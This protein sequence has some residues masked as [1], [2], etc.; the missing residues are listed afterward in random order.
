MTLPNPMIYSEKTR[1]T[2][3]HQASSSSPNQKL[4]RRAGDLSSSNDLYGSQQALASLQST[5]QAGKLRLSAG[6]RQA[7]AAKLRKGSIAQV[8]ISG[9][10]RL[11]H[12]LSIKKRHS[13]MIGGGAE[14]RRRKSS[15]A[16]SIGALFGAHARPSQ[17]SPSLG[18]AYDIEEESLRRGQEILDKYLEDKER[19]AEQLRAR[20]EAEQEQQQQQQHGATGSSP[21]INRKS[22]NSAGKS[23]TTAGQSG[24][25]AGGRDQRTGERQPL[26]KSVSAA[27]RK[28]F[29]ASISRLL[30]MRHSS[31]KLIQP[32]QPLLTSLLASNTSSNQMQAATANNQALKHSDSSACTSMQVGETVKDKRR[33]LF[34][35]KRSETVNEPSVSINF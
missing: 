2:K 7:R 1:S 14:L 16:A 33:H 3:A 35:I 21:D 11:S 18:A 29:K 6:E 19:E 8:S 34:K 5:K 31:S 10:K 17:P 27:N 25:Y 9:V 26:G 4:D 12:K 30:F 32:S 20:L 15:A 22:P 28:S 23:S 13:N 24:G